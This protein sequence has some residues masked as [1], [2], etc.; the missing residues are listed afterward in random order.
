MG[1]TLFWLKFD[2]A[3]AYFVVLVYWPDGV[4]IQ[5]KFLFLL[6]DQTVLNLELMVG[7]RKYI[8]LNKKVSIYKV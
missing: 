6:Q 1:C 2:H 4:I 3:F 8:F 5:Y 7:K